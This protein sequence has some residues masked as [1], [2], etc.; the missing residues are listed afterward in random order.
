MRTR[1]PREYM[2]WSS[3]RERCTNASLGHYK[4]YGGRGIRVCERWMN[5]FDAFF[6]DMGVRPEGLTLDRIDVNGDYEPG[7][8]RWAT[9]AVQVANRRPRKKRA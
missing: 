3:M 8:C 6:E 1:Y 7:N 4:H 5:S 9:W 2:T